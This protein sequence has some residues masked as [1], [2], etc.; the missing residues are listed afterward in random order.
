MHDISFAQN[1]YS[2]KRNYHCYS[3]LISLD[4]DKLE[5]SNLKA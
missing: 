1:D 5:L 4:I 2:I 3:F